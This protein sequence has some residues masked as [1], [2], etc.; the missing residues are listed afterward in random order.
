MCYWTEVS[1][2]GSEVSVAIGLQ[3]EIGAFSEF[4]FQNGF[5][6]LFLYWEEVVAAVSPKK[7]KQTGCEFQNF[8]VFY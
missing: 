4:L 8:S 2:V 1:P 6:L 7:N 5:L 3:L